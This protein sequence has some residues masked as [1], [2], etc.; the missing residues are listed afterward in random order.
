MGKIA[1]FSTAAEEADTR[2]E[3]VVRLRMGILDRTGA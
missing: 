3:G 1:I 2:L